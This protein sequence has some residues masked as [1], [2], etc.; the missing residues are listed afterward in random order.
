MA[1]APVVHFAP[2]STPSLP[3]VTELELAVQSLRAG[4]V[5]AYPTEAVWGL[6][7][8]PFDAAAVQRLL[9]MKGRSE[10]KGLIL[11]AADIAQVE[12]WLAALS[13]SQKQAVFATW[14]GPY[15]WVVPAA[16]A[17]RWL[18]GEH[19]SLAV[20]VSAHP[21]VQA[22]CRAWGGPLVSTSANRS[23]QPPLADAADLRREFGDALGHILPGALGGDAKPTEIRDAV[24]GVVLRA[25]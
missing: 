18:R 5:I 19:D 9:V 1:P 6:G 16:S 3:S 25:R 4:Q 8:D 12:S 14:P 11:I 10:A 7:C 21:G 22:L 2:M 23:G 20:R 15:T 24:T 17:P 13:D